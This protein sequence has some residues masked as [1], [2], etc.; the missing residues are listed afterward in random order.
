[1][2]ESLLAIVLGLLPALVPAAQQPF[3]ADSLAGIERQ[4]TGE[5]FLLV[6]WSVDCPPCYRELEILGRVQQEYPQM[7]LVLVATDPITMQHETA[8]VLEEYRLE[9]S[10]NWIFA[11]SHVERLRYS[12]DPQWYG[13]LPRSY[14]YD[15]EHQRTAHS[16]VLTEAQVRHWFAEPV[17]AESPGEAD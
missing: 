11:D 10:A 16:G 12:I 2:R 3:H 1:M 6:L 13:E 9:V 14:F 4:F 5:S 17:S 15:E 7:N 8:M